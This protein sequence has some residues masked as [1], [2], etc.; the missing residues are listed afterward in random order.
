MSRVVCADVRILYGPTFEGRYFTTSISVAAYPDLL[1][2]HALFAKRTR[3]FAP[4]VGQRPGHNQ[5]F[6]DGPDAH[7]LKRPVLFHAAGKTVV[8]A[9]TCRSFLAI[10]QR[11]DAE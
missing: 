9:E 7:I 6:L 10:I 5:P 2:I 11:R 8:R 3:R 4:K 1:D